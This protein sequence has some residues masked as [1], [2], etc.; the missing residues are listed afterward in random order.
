[1]RADPA[2]TVPAPKGKKP[3]TK[4]P[5]WDREATEYAPGC[6]TW[7]A[8]RLEWTWN[9]AMGVNTWT[10]VPLHQWQAVAFF[11]TLREATI[12]SEGYE[13]GRNHAEKRE[14]GGR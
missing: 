3:K 7:T 1:M 2:Q 13:A 4:K 8:A 6:W 9:G 5:F 12:F 11:K 14:A 10:R